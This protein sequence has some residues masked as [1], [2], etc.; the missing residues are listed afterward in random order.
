[1]VFEPSK[2]SNI[3]VLLRDS[4]NN[5]LDNLVRPQVHIRNQTWA[6]FQ[7]C[8]YIGLALAILLTMTLVMY[9]GLSPWIMAGIVL[10]AVS[11]LLGLTMVTKIIRGEERIINYH[12]QI[13]VLVTTAILLW[14]LGQPILPYLDITMIG[15][16]LFIACGRIGCLMNGCCH[17]QPH[18]WGVCY[19]T[20][21]IATGFTRYL[22]GVRLFPIQAIESLWVFFI[23]LVGSAFVLIGR[24]PG[25]ALTW[26]IVGYSVGRFF[27][28]S[29]RGDPERPYY[30]GYSEPQW[31]SVIVL[32]LVVAAELTNFLP[33]HL[34]HIGA[35][36]FLIGI[37]IVV[38]IK[39][40]LQKTMKH[41]LLHPHHIREVAK[42][43]EQTPNLTK[44][45][46]IV[47]RQKSTPGDIHVGY[48]SLGIQI[49]TGKIENT[50]GDI[51]HYTLSCQNRI[52]AEEAART[53]AELILQLKHSSGPSEIVRGNQ[54]VY[55]L[56]IHPKP[57]LMHSN[58][59]KSQPQVEPTV[60]KG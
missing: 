10:T 46:P 5:Y 29:M 1:M 59:I 30:W 47:S 60:A 36:V 33:F 26:Y 50:A 31:I 45:S 2:G 27:F 7:L 12:H 4:F 16:G 6:T 52:M 37:I 38:T 39:R 41:Q 11:I 32:I 43:I 49:S 9:W 25:E 13:A 21:Y 56:L 44:Q 24:P 19:R 55:H 42:V 54:G 35:A 51:T 3:N 8:G 22:I 58:L 23:V 18:C 48:T 34:W 15:V 57:G 53:L 14:F 28:E 40:R 17:G 20:E